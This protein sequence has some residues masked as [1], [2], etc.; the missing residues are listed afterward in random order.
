MAA[1]KRQTIEYRYYE[2]P[3][4][5]YVL[6]MLGEPW[7]M[8][9]GTDEKDLM[10]FHNYLEIGYCYWGNGLL[11]I[12]E[13]ELQYKGGLLTLI[14]QNIPHTTLSEDNG[15]CKWEFLFID[16]NSFIRKEMQ[17]KRLVPEEVIKKIGKNSY[18]LHWNENR[19]LTNIVVSIL[20]EYREQ[21]PYFKQSV[22]GYLR[23]LVIEMLRIS[24]DMSSSVTIDE[25]RVNNYI[26]NSVNYFAEHYVE[27]IKMQDVANMCGLSESHFRRVFGESIGMK[28]L[29]YLN[30][31][32]V[33]KA[34]EILSNE[35]I[36]VE[37]VGY[38]VGFQNP[39]TFGRNFKKLIGQ[40][41][42]QWKKET[43]TTAGIIKNLKITAKK[44]W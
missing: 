23:A 27:D 18:V 17:F 8:H 14:P 32:R 24:E 28:P 13:T 25:K 44:G 30:M 37:E 3:A 26:E 2:I 40:T 9:Y 19:Q 41:P 34:C 38:R 22:I 35:D 10:H 31:V 12:E 1:Q 5:Q 33:N 29:D 6:A 21:K 43:A 15:I 4:D 42:Y 36:S 20:E 11:R 16:I 39:S 7:E